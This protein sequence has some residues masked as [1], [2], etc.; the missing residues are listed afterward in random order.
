M[1]ELHDARNNT[2]AEFVSLSANALN[3]IINIVHENRLTKR[4]FVMFS[5]AD[6]MATVEA[7]AA[8]SKRAGALMDG[9][10]PSSEKFSAMARI[11][12]SET[13]QLVGVA[14]AKIVT[15][16]GMFDGKKVSEFLE[17]ISHNRLLRCY[18]GLI[19]DMDRVADNLFE[20]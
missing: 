12:A 4:Q 2:G 10:D 8:F 14:A 15:G 20:R 11:Y 19:E 9:G 16:S 13:A 6:M 5:L 3:D 7:A 17:S 18:S 1:R